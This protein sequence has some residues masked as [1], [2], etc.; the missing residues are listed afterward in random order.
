[1]S[2]SKTPSSTPAQT[3]T[4]TS[5]PVAEKKKFNWR[6]RLQTI[7]A[8]STEGLRRIFKKR[9]RLT[10][11]PPSAEEIAAKKAARWG[12]LQ[13]HRWGMYIMISIASMIAGGA[14]GILLLSQY[15]QYQDAEISRLQERIKK[16]GAS[17]QKANK[18]N[19]AL[20]TKLDK[21]ES[22]AKQEMPTNTNRAPDNK[23]ESREAPQQKRRD[24]TFTSGNLSALKECLQQFDR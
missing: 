1:M 12:W 14:I 22:Q 13:K 17:L 20:K 15:N 24:C 5:P 11:Q 9:S 21:H 16:T 4:E 3:Q 8:R 6:S 10:V 2:A 23:T 19:A 7:V 18:E